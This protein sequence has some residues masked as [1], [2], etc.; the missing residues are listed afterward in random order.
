MKN[1]HIDFNKLSYFYTDLYRD[2]YKNSLNEF[3]NLIEELL[4]LNKNINLLI[5]H[6]LFSRNNYLSSFYE[7]FCLLKLVIN[8]YREDEKLTIKLSNYRQL[9]LFKNY[10]KKKNNIIFD[11]PSS[12]TYKIFYRQITVFF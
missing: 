2:I 4:V 6:P 7:D 12:S 8:S 3:N 1:N 5:S 9:L 11:Y 10:F